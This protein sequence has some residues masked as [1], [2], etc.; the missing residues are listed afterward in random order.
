MGVMVAM[1]LYAPPPSEQIRTRD[2]FAPA[3]D[4]GRVRLMTYNVRRCYGMDGTYAPERIARV[5]AQ[6]GA[7][8]IALQELDMNRGRSGAVDQALA[9]ASVLGMTHHFHPA[10]S[11]AEEHYGDAILSALPLRLVKAAALPGVPLRPRLE[12][13]GA[14]WVEVPLG[15][16]TLQVITSHFGLLGRERRL[17]AQ[18]LL[19]PEWLGHPA[20]RGPVAL[21]GD[22]N[23]IPASGAYRLL[24][25]RLRD[26]Q[27]LPPFRARATFPSAWPLL[28]IDHVFV[29]PE[30]VVRD[31]TVLRD[32]EARVASDHLPVCVDLELPPAG[33]GATP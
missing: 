31:V 18:A 4:A 12:P 6:S 9:I 32:G 5:I 28:R 22:F 11:I 8:I 14:L 13:R 25:K 33:P 7:Q 23:A 26:V 10:M 24:T 30:L 15:D 20:C 2:T 1:T 21:L 3:A 17:Q 29:S 27:R 19:G 16:R